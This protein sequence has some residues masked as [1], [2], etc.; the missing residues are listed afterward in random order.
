MF[1]LIALPLSLVFVVGAVVVARSM[2]RGRRSL[3]RAHD[4][5]PVSEQWL[6]DRRRS[7]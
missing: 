3:R 2:R 6:A 5:T 1:P 7:D 4:L